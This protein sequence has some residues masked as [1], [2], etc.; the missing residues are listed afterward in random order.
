M[1]FDGPVDQ[2]PGWKQRNGTGCES[3]CVSWKFHP[4]KSFL[5]S[6]FFSYYVFLFWVF[7]AQVSWLPRKS[8]HRFGYP[9]PDDHCAQGLPFCFQLGGML[10]GWMSLQ[11]P[12]WH[13][14]PRQ[15]LSSLGCITWVWVER[16]SLKSGS[17]DS[18]IV[19]IHLLWWMILTLHIATT[20][21]RKPRNMATCWQNIAGPD[22]G[23]FFKSWKQKATLFYAVNLQNYHERV[24]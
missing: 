7:V 20:G 2:W 21:F 19:I 3:F 23:P 4:S 13:C 10:F 24:A 11:T 17:L 22:K 8:K 15:V 18:T 12:C 5:S 6:S 9:Y 14:R 16:G 1:G